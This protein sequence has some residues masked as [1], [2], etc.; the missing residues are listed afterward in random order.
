MF[1]ELIN[2]KQHYC[3]LIDLL[4]NILGNQFNN[5]YMNSTKQIYGIG[6]CRIN[7]P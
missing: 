3:Q 2:F 4:P 1:T 6:I 5:K 7:V